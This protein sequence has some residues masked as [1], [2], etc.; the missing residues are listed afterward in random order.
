MRYLGLEKLL[1]EKIHEIE[2]TCGK[3]CA[4]SAEINRDRSEVSCL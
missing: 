2:D 1:G 3:L 4:A